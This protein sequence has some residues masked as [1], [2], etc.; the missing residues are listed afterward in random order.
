MSSKWLYV[1]PSTSCHTNRQYWQQMLG[2]IVQIVPLFGNRPSGGCKY[3]IGLRSIPSDASSSSWASLNDLHMN[4][5]T[6]HT[7]VCALPALPS[8][9]SQRHLRLQHD[10]HG[11]QLSHS[12]HI[13]KWVCKWLFYQINH[14]ISNSGQNNISESVLS[15]LDFKPDVEK[16]IETTCWSWKMGFF[17]LVR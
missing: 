6:N 5:F 15:S 3:I 4:I 1:S 13:A 12:N 16:W 11:S 10:T 9:E 14:N 17:C 7:V 2:K 8:Y